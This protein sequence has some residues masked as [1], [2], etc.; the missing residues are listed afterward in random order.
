MQPKNRVFQHAISDVKLPRDMNKELDNEQ[1]SNQGLISKDSIVVVSVEQISCDLIGDAVILDLKK[2]IYYG[3]DEVGARVW[4][5]I[6]EP[7]R[8]SDVL[9]VLLEE[10]EVDRHRCESDVLDLLRDLKGRELIEIRYEAT[11]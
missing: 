10:Y 9:D 5:L 11:A 1:S 6:K 8:V 2:G 7:R 3:L 4:S